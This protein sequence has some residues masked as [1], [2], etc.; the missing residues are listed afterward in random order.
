VFGFH[1]G[2]AQCSQEAS[3]GI[4]ETFFDFCEACY[5]SGIDVFQ[6]PGHRFQLQLTVAN[7]LLFHACQCHRTSSALTLM[8]F[9]V[10]D[11]C[12]FRLFLFLLRKMEQYVETVE[13][14]IAQNNGLRLLV[15]Q[16]GQLLNGLQEL[17]Q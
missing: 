8:G 3:I 1:F 7:P 12:V 15:L 9:D 17:V 2:F 11:P 4:G 13:F 5:L 6:G 16:G 14:R 10:R